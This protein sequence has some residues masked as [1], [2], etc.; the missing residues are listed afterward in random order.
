MAEN[1]QNSLTCNINMCEILN[2]RGD[3]PLI[4]TNGINDKVTPRP[5][6]TKIRINLIKNARTLGILYA[7]QSNYKQLIYG[8]IK[9]NNKIRHGKNERPEDQVG[10]GNLMPIWN[11]LKRIRNGKPN[12][13]NELYTHE[14]KTKSPPNYIIASQTKRLYN[15]F[16]KNTICAIV[17]KLN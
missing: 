13:I 3:I 14:M 4:Q 9:K 1:T 15:N 16:Y 17:N 7:Q 10:N 2:A 6:L 5:D 12:Y 8:E 11:E